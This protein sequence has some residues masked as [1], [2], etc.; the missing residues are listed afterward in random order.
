MAQ[1][2][3]KTVQNRIT[4]LALPSYYEVVFFND[5]ETTMDFVVNILMSIFHKTKKQAE[6]LAYEIDGNGEG[7]AGKYTFDIAE[8]K[9]E[10]A[11]LAARAEGF[12]LQISTRKE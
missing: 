1:T 6:A 2:S 11:T 12:P 7:V 10:Q 5:D 3:T 8:T 4:K 9:K